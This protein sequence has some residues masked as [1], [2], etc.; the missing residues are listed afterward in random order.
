MKI[1][2][3]WVIKAFIEK[4]TIICIY[5]ALYAV[6]AW[7]QDLP[8][9]AWALEGARFLLCGACRKAALRA[10]RLSPRLKREQNHWI[11][12]LY[13]LI[14]DCLAPKLHLCGVGSPLT[15][16]NVCPLR[17]KRPLLGHIRPSP[18]KEIKAQRKKEEEGNRKR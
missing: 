3:C 5:F 18:D 2:V 7:A 17:V 12:R 9:T 14:S 1:S 15:A 8:H 6:K 16:V 11:N 10:L 4:Y 13:G